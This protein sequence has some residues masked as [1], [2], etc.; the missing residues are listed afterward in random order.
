M[1]YKSA[2]TDTFAEG[3][4]K[5]ATIQLSEEAT[6]EQKLFAEALT[7]TL[8]SLYTEVLGLREQ[9]ESLRK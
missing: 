9:V 6:T 3:I 4:S 2:S 8:S 7:R 5:L 1:P